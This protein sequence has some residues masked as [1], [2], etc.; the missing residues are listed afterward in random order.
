MPFSL[1]ARKCRFYGSLY[2]LVMLDPRRLILLREVVRHG[3]FSQAAQALFLTQPAVSRQIA[4]LEREAGVRLLERTPTGLRLTDAGLVVLD[5]AEAIVGHLTA[6]E[7]E[8]EAITTLGAGRLRLSA[9]PTVASTL[10]LDAIRLFRRRHPSVELTFVESGT[11]AGLQRL[12]AGE[13]DL[14]VAF[15]ERGH[16]A[17]SSW[18]GLHA[19][20]LLVDPLWVALARGHRL[21]SKDAIRLRDL[22]DDGWIQAVRAGPAGIT[23]RAC[24]AAGFEPRIT[25]LSDHAPITQGLVAA[26][27]GVSLVSSLSMPQ[28]RKDIVIRPL[29]PAGPER[30]VFAVSLPGRLRPPAIT[31]MVEIL[32]ELAPRYERGRKSA[33]VRPS[34]VAAS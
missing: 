33:A 21:A 20:H 4:K 3:S 17:P 16:P 1:Y 34:S 30:D 27:V 10:V 19:E 15:R 5:R 22:R 8:L 14:A 18:D 12:R 31:A 11:T 24:L 2:T 32:G 23:Y 13:V 25:A 9:F 7:A 6:A 29:K 28:A 26:G